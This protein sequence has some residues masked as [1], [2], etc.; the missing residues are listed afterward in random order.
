MAPN[1]V[2]ETNALDGEI[3]PKSGNAE[4]T[5]THVRGC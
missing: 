4:C 1:V 3:M 2:T 5:H